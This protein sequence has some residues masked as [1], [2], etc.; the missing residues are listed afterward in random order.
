MGMFD[1]Q[2]DRAT[3]NFD[4]IAKSRITQIDKMFDDKIESIRELLNGISVNVNVNAGQVKKPLAANPPTNEDVQ[5][6]S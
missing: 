4:A 5:P 6:T 3:A 1:E 2:I